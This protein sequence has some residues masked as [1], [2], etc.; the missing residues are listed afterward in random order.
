MPFYPINIFSST[1]PALSSLFFLSHLECLTASAQLTPTDSSHLLSSQHRAISDLTLLQHPPSSPT[2]P[3]MYQAQ[4][5][6][7]LTFLAV[8]TDIQEQAISRSHAEKVIAVLRGPFSDIALFKTQVERPGDR[9]RIVSR[10]IRSYQNTQYPWSALELFISNSVLFLI[11]KQAPRTISQSSFIFLL[12][13]FQ[14][15]LPSLCS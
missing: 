4:A 12:L 10:L 1:F 13:H 9:R 5:E 7:L 8:L 15:M 14:V 11:C 2:M 3:R 6:K